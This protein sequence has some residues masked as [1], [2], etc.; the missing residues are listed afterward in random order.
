MTK[1][2]KKTKT[3][4]C[5]THYQSGNKARHLTSAFHTRWEE[6]RK[7]VQNNTIY[8]NAS[9]DNHVGQQ[10]YYNDNN[11]VEYP[12]YYN[13]SSYDNTNNYVKYPTYYNNVSYDYND[14][15]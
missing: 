15:Y 14:T 8:D 12:N 7:I 13:N 4:E 6:N 9:Y 11:Y 3:C 10:T 5:G 1:R 2:V